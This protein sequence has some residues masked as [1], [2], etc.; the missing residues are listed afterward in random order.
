MLLS[1]ALL[2]KFVGHNLEGDIA[3]ELGEMDSPHVTLIA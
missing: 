2:A 3:V 1:W